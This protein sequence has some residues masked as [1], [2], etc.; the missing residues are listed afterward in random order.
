IVLLARERRVCE[1]VRMRPPCDR[2]RGTAARVL[3]DPPYAL[4][5]SAMQPGRANSASL[6]AILPEPIEMRS[7]MLRDGGTTTLAARPNIPLEMSRG[8]SPRTRP[9]LRV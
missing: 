8:E 6:R 4:A 5:V 2:A 3:T 9:V 7:T 1:V